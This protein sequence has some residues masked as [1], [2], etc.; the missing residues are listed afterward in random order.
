MAKEVRHDNSCKFRLYPNEE[1]R[2]LIAKTFGCCRWVCN[3]GLAMRKKHG[4]RRK[5]YWNVWHVQIIIDSDYV[6]NTEQIKNQTNHSVVMACRL[7]EECL[8]TKADTCNVLT[9]NGKEKG[10]QTS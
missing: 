1:Q 5:I 8:K 3:W 10:M 7:L 4:K 9:Y 2:V 6:R